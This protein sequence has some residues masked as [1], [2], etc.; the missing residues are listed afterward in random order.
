MK[1][2]KLLVLSSVCLSGLVLSTSDVWAHGERSL[3][4]FVRMRT[5]QWY[6]VNWSADKVAVN[7]EL[8]IT[9]K[10]HVAEDWPNSIPKPEAAYLGV[11]APGPVFLRKERWINGEAHL[12]SLPLKIG[13][14]YEFKMKLKARIPGRYHIHPSFNIIDTGNVAGPGLWV[15]IT[16]NA[17][18]FTNT[19]QT[20][21]GEM[22]NLETYGIANGVRWHMLWMILGVAWLVWWIR[23]PLFIPRYAMVNK[24]EEDELVTSNDKNLAKAILVVVP[25]IV[26]S[27]YFMANNQYPETIPLQASLD[28][29]PPL[30]EQPSLVNAK[31]KR[32]TYNIPQRSMTMMVEIKNESSRPVQIGEFTT[33][34]VRFINS[35]MTIDTSHTPPEYL[36]T[37]GMQIEPNDWIQPG[38]NKVVKVV[39]SDAVWE[40]EHLSSVIRDADSRFGGLLFLFDDQGNRHLTSI[41]APLIPEYK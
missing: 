26:L 24:G 27:G 39:A 12:N 20:V 5:V 41:S 8:I 38:E 31:V 23:R 33:G 16:G 28:L 18:A 11:I 36:A 3:E 4:P 10:I 30:S 37:N 25:V 7:D 1:L 15:E 13:R 6:D 29:I 35:N 2:F 22:I 32:A 17:N 40:T 34:S 21:H 14:D 9:G 19:V